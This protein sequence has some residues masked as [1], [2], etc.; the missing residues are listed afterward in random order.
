MEVEVA[1]N[2]HFGEV[3][4]LIRIHMG[5]RNTFSSVAQAATLGNFFNLH[6]YKMAAAR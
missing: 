3:F 5:F 2:V 6:K 4:S 1:G